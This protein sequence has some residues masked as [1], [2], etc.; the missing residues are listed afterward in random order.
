MDDE[1]ERQRREDP[2]RWYHWP[3]MVWV[4][5]IIIT[6][7]AYKWLDERMKRDGV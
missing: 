7:H 4:G 1:L 6:V 3:G 5:L 2:M